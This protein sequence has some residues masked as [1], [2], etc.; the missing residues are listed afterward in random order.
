MTSSH[1]HKIDRDTSFSFEVPHYEMSQKETADES[2]IQ[3]GSLKV[4]HKISGQ[5]LSVRDTWIH[6]QSYY[7]S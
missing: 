6:W 3:K 2:L 4:D 1:K 7:G 5:L